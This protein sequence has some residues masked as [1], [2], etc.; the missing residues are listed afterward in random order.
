MAIA[1]RQLQFTSEIDRALV[2]DCDVHQGDGTADIFQ[3][4]PTVYTFSIHAAKNYPVRKVRSDLD[5]GLADGTDDK[6]YLTELENHLPHI[7]Q[8]H[9]PDIV[10]YNA[11]V[12]P[13]EDDRLGRLALS[14]K[15]L[16]ARD[17]FV[18]GTVREAGLPITCVVGGGYSNDIEVLAQRHAGMYRVAAE[19]L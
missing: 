12:D 8:A 13:H 14:D 4:D 6:G 19:L 3:S 2:I 16:S 1:I 17:R 7:I 15:G 9:R 5:I 10:F 18:I 11:G